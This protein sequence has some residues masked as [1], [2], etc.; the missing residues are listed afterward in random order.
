MY[1][2]IW[3]AYGNPVQLQ[4]GASGVGLTHRYVLCYEFHLVWVHMLEN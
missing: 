3:H 4:A 1:A 2:Y